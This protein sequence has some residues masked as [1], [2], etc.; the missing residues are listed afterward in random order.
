MA[1]GARQA[2]GANLAIG[3]TGIA[4]PGGETPEKPVGTTWIGLVSAEG[5]WTRQFVWDG[6]RLENKVKSAEAAL[7]MILDYLEG[8]LSG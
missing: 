3:V 6:N 1:R 8:T 4:G 7:Q 5:E 2:L